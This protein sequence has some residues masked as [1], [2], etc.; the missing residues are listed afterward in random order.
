MTLQRSSGLIFLLYCPRRYGVYL[1]AVK[2]L[3]FPTWPRQPIAS[4]KPGVLTAM[5]HLLRYRPS[6]HRTTAGSQL[7]KVAAM[8]NTVVPPRRVLTFASTTSATARTLG[9]VN[10]GACS[11]TVSV[12]SSRTT[13][14]KEGI[15]ETPRPAANNWSGRHK[16]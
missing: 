3:T 6:G 13:V 9:A 4:W 14:Q 8:W 15:R 10:P 5:S 7:T 11:T 12:A 1:Q 16:S 2:S